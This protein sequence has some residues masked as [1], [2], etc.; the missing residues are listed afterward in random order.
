MAQTAQAYDLFN[1][2]T[3][4]PQPT[5]EIRYSQG[6]QPNNSLGSLFSGLG[7]IVT[8]A[9]TGAQKL[10]QTKIREEVAPVVDE[11]TDRFT[12]RGPSP[13]GA[14]PDSQVPDEI[15]RTGER[16]SRLT[17]A[18]KAGTVLNSHYWGLLDMEARRLRAK[19][20]GFR[21][22]IDN[23]FQ[24]MT[25]SVP[26]NALRRSLME[27]AHRRGGVDPEKEYRDWEKHVIDQTPFGPQVMQ[28][29]SEGR[30]MTL[31]ELKNLAAN[32]HATAITTQQRR[33]QLELQ[34]AQGNVDRHTAMNAASD[35]VWN[36][37]NTAWRG[38]DFNAL[39][40]R[41]QE[42]NA[43]TGPGGQPELS[44]NEQAAISQAFTQFRA[45]LNQTVRLRMAE[46]GRLG[47]HQEDAA[48]IQKNVEQT[49]KN[50]EEDVNHGR[51]SLVASYRSM[52]EGLNAADRFTAL[53][54]NEQIRRFNQLRENLGPEGLNLALL[55][56]PSLLR[57]TT[58]AA[59]NLNLSTIFGGPQAQ[60]QPG[61][62]ATP[63]PASLNDVHQQNKAS[64]VTDPN[65]YNSTRRSAIAVVTNPNSTPEMA[66]RA[67]D[68]LYGQRNSEYLLQFP[69]GST[70][71]SVFQ[72]M[73]APAITQRMRELRDSGNTQAWNAYS[74]WVTSNAATMALQPS[75]DLV[76]T[77]SDPN[78][79]LRIIYNQQTNQLEVGSELTMLR[80]PGSAAVSDPWT[81][82][83]S[84]YAGAA[85]VWVNQ[86]NQAL[87]PLSA[88]GTAAQ[89]S[90][91]GAEAGA[92]QNMLHIH[93][94]KV[95]PDPSNPNQMVVRPLREGQTLPARA[96]LQ[97]IEGNAPEGSVGRSSS[98]PTPEEQSQMALDE[99]S[100]RGRNPVQNVPEGQR[101]KAA[102]DAAREDLLDQGL[103]PD[104]EPAKLQAQID[105]YMKEFGTGQTQQVRPE[106][107]REVDTATRENRPFDWN[108]VPLS[109]EE[110]TLMSDNLDE[111]RKSQSH[112]SRLYRD[113]VEQ[114]DTEAASR[115]R[116]RLQDVETQAIQM[117]QQMMTLPSRMTAPQLPQPEP[118]STP[119]ASSQTTVP[120]GQT[121]SVQGN[122]SNWAEIVSGYS[123]AEVG[124]VLRIA[125]KTG[126]AKY[127][128]KVPNGWLLLDHAPGNQ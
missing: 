126:E 24:D 77:L 30:P 107:L 12:G 20:P 19:Y 89:G 101:R 104:K 110:R 85:R 72:E 11:I 99:A 69:T 48:N 103:D 125:N 21:D 6:A 32:H 8:E 1:P 92:V 25:G 68:A 76:R 35:A 118:T 111:V 37:I 124:T 62:T 38:P 100:N 105:K 122:P 80:R 10:F 60:P 45:T 3:N 40:Q 73:S 71:N 58:Q 75:Q 43:R 102:E 13:A 55:S 53:T 54:T 115:Y 2:D 52:L 63:P 14:G 97:G 42:A 51:T 90:Q 117:E 120:V 26:A 33:S 112:W 96:G 9:A 5:E 108:N 44:A 93:G 23:V 7:D 119:S 87:L 16:L 15:T 86:L 4:T 78:S 39:M 50:L 83:A 22:Y 128:Q 34:T 65:V 27:E 123:N 84:P 94:L 66:D 113:A 31:D 121:I 81:T 17:A 46:Y 70:R 79:R 57:A 59:T 49:L 98:P 29:R 114:G 64:G 127:V 18:E 88:L 91:E 106:V 95:V 36:D 47:L 67:V 82:T 28:R 61:A 41:M 56:N 74:N 109:E 116:T